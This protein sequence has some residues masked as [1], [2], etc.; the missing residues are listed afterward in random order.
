MTKT[1]ASST[2]NCLLHSAVPAYWD[3][4]DSGRMD[5][6]MTEN[7]KVIIQSH[8]G[9]G[10]GEPYKKKRNEKYNFLVNTPADEPTKCFVLL[11]GCFDLFCFFSL[12]RRALRSAF[13][14][15][16][17]STSQPGDPLVA[18]SML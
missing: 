8:E 15:T 14:A 12:A 5:I 17:T 7:P 3:S 13:C 1:I 10:S 16:R 11:C 18:T 9:Y 2:F 6:D 4:G